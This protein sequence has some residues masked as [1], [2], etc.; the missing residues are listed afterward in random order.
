MIHMAV[1]TLI[2]T[3]QMLSTYLVRLAPIHTHSNDVIMIPLASITVYGACV[4]VN[5]TWL[6]CNNGGCGG[7]RLLTARTTNVLFSDVLSL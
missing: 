4:P 3:S 2:D 5:Q 6:Q 1:S 7:S